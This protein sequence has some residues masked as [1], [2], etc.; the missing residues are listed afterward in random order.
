MFG[1]SPKTIMTDKL[2]KEII[3]TP[4]TKPKIYIFT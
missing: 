4:D 2:F 3:K 1:S